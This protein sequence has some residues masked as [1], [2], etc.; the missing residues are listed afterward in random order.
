M[1]ITEKLD[2]FIAR[3]GKGID[4]DA[5]NVALARLDQK[6]LMI[7]GRDAEIHQLKE[8]IEKLKADLEMVGAG[9]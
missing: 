4:R 8:E 7:E 6:Q 2:Q 3:E 9:F 5:L 1:T